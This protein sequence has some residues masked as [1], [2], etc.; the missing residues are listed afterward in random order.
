MT[1]ELIAFPTLR[2]LRNCADIIAYENARG[3]MDATTIDPAVPPGI[4]SIPSLPFAPLNCEIRNLVRR[5]GSIF[6]S[7]THVLNFNVLF[8]KYN[9]LH[10]AYQHYIAMLLRNNRLLI[11]I[12]I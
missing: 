11:T 4:I 1:S 8:D 12:R 3:T 6:P 2:V 10:R 9:R 5:G 7:K